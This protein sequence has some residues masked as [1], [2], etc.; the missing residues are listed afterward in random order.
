MSRPLFIKT[1]SG[2]VEGESVWQKTANGW[3]KGQAIGGRTANGWQMSDFG[4]WIWKQGSKYSPYHYQY[5]STNPDRIQNEGEC[6]GQQW[7]YKGMYTDFFLDKCTLEV[8]C[9]E[10]CKGWYDERYNDHDWGEWEEYTGSTRQRICKRD[11]IDEL[12]HFQRCGDFSNPDNEQYF[13]HNFTEVSYIDE[14]EHFCSCGR[15]GYGKAEG[16]NILGGYI[17]PRDPTCE[18]F[19]S[20]GGFN[21]SKCSYTTNIIIPP[22][23]HN[24]TNASVFYSSNG[25]GTHNATQY[26]Q[27]GCGSYVMTLQGCDHYGPNG[28][29]MACGYDWNP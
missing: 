11:T 24:Y 15:C 6:Y 21:C 17:P 5:Y 12:T 3:V 9:C 26:C 25:D 2:W 27:N 16:H 7:E 19:G 22:T 29:C 13:S 20:T 18:E 28:S 23:G 8:K 1:S 10:Q 14:L 4:Q